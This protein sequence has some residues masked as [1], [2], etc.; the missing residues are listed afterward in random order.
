MYVSRNSGKGVGDVVQVPFS[1]WG[2]VGAPCSSAD[3]SMVSADSGLSST[4][5]QTLG[6]FVLAGVL[7]YVG[8]GGKS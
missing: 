5:L 8:F 4:A 7:L 2:Y 3:G 6:G 1:S